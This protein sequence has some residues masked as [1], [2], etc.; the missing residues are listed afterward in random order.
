MVIEVE[1][2]ALCRIGKEEI[3]PESEMIGKMF[4]MSRVGCVCVCQRGMAGCHQC[5]DRVYSPCYLSCHKVKYG[6]IFEVWVH[7]L[8]PVTCSTCILHV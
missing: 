5:S 3:T 4:R 6:I 1:R 7:F 2:A 8:D